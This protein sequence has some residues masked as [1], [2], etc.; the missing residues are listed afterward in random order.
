MT[1]N[2]PVVMPN[3]KLDAIMAALTTMTLDRD[4]ML[5][6][7]EELNLRLHNLEARPMNEVYATVAALSTS[8]HQATIVEPRV[9]LPEK[10]DGTRSKF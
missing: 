5:K 4:H 3:D 1:S 7:N 6:Q 8:G 10:F 9:S 2:Q